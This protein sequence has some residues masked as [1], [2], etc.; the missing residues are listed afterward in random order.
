MSYH[1]RITAGEMRDAPRK[2]VLMQATIISPAGPQL[3]I[4]RDMTLTGARIQPERPLE[5]D[6]ELIF[7]RGADIRPA[8]VVWT[9]GEEAGLQFYG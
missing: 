4:I 2:H 1:G 8:R 3:A 9:T 6:W 5:Q 7:K